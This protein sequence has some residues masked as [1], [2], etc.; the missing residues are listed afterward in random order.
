MN[1][2]IQQSSLKHT[3]GPHG[4]HLRISSNCTDEPTP[5][6]FLPTLVSPMEAKA[7]LPARTVGTL[8]IAPYNNTCPSLSSTQYQNS[9]S[10]NAASNVVKGRI[11]RENRRGVVG[12]IFIHWWKQRSWLM[13]N[14]L[15]GGENIDAPALT[16]EPKEKQRYPQTQPK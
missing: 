2:Q 11:L 10:S 5:V 6:Y 9:S 7:C 8:S 16:E 15:G 14:L 3:T 12:E 13:N 4:K 1:S